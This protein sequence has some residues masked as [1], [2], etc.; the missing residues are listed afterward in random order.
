MLASMSASPLDILLAKMQAFLS[1][2]THPGFGTLTT[3]AD[4]AEVE[5]TM[6]P[7]DGEAFE[8]FAR[9]VMAYANGAPIEWT[10][11]NRKIPLARVRRRLN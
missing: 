6:K 10:I 3:S 9:R 8:A 4:G 7:S 2:E 11:Q 1:D 5:V